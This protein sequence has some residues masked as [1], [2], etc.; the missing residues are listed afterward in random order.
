[1]IETEIRKVGNSA[2][3]TLTSEMLAR[4]DNKGGNPPFVIRDDDGSLRI[5]AHDP[6]LAEPLTAAEMVMDKN[7]DLLTA[8]A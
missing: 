8:L 3:M 1:M 7:G 2:V 6:S 5:M 4:P